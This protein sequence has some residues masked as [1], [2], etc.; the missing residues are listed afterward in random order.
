MS[1]S[2]A[3]T[4]HTNDNCPLTANEV[5]PLVADRDARR[6]SRPAVR[7]TAVDTERPKDR[8]VGPGAGPL[9]VPNDR[10]QSGVPRVH[11]AQCVSL[12]IITSP[13]VVNSILI[14]QSRFDG[15]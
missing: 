6:A 3:A 12:T 13:E 10:P 1:S 5:T 7:V 9:S 4:L 11:Q 8:T 15:P 2:N 14:I